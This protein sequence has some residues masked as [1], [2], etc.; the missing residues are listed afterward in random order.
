MA[1]RVRVI[2]SVLLGLIGLSF[3]VYSSY[4]VSPGQIYKSDPIYKAESSEDFYRA[5]NKSLHN[6]SFQDERNQNVML[7]ALMVTNFSIVTVPAVETKKFTSTKAL[8]LEDITRESV[9]QKVL[10]VQKNKYLDKNKGIKTEDLYVA[11]F[12]IPCVDLCPK[13]GD[14]LKILILITSAL[15]HSEARSA[16]RQT[17]GHYN[18]RND[19]AIAFVVGI[20][21]DS[22]NQI[23]SEESN[24]YGDI[25]QGNFVDS[26]DNLTLKTVAMM[27]WIHD[28]CPDTHFILKTDD[29]MFIN[30]PK[31]LTF[32]VK[33]QNSKMTFFGRLAKKWRPIRKSSSKYY[34]SPVQ[35]SPNMF[36]DFTTGPAYLFTSDVVS[37]VYTKA[38]ETTYLKLEDVF[39]TGVVAQSLK[40]KRQHVNEFFN[41]RIPLNACTIKKGISIHMIKYHEQFELWKKLLDGRSKCK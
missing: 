28:Y 26:Y 15:D 36:P 12:N 9:V 5:Q 27:E 29:D 33:H 7:E 17:W 18:L 30:V 38:L 24:L 11:G 16:I 4:Y 41:K 2:H 6:V 34:V 21:S 14:G 13:L 39:T 35:Y 1:F 32:L 8:V 23:V 22:G 31:L 25:I 20:G 40:I 37:D 3:I 10:P 19:V